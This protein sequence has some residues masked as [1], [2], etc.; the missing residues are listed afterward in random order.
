MKL[1]LIVASLALLSL[2]G[3]VPSYTEEAEKGWIHAP[4]EKIGS[5]LEDWIEFY[6]SDYSIKELKNFKNKHTG[7][8]MIAFWI[9]DGSTTAKFM[10]NLVTNEQF[11]TEVESVSEKFLTKLGIDK[12][13][14]DEHGN[15]DLN[16]HW[17]AGANRLRV[18]RESSGHFGAVWNYYWD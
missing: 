7:D 9:T 2:L 1:S 11:L 3:A 12:V 5:R 18:N 4:T 16:D 15:A 10:I 8:L 6:G 17:D 14:L 13:P